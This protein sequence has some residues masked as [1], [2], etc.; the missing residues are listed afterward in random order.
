MEAAI[1]FDVPFVPVHIIAKQFYCEKQVEM[2]LLRGKPEASEAVRR[3]READQPLFDPAGDLGLR[4][5]ILPGGFHLGDPR[6]VSS[7]SP[8]RFAAMRMAAGRAG[9]SVRARAAPLRFYPGS[10]WGINRAPY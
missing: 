2:I 5:P 7:R 3:G 6:H 1:R 10:A 4:D 8:A 9:G